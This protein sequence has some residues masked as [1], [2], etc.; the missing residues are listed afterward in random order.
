MS[1]GQEIAPHANFLPAFISQSHSFLVFSDDIKQGIEEQTLLV[2]CL[3]EVTLHVIF[4]KDSFCIH[5]S[6]T[7]TDILNF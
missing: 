3:I 5:Q 1:L 6:E 2:I 4:I 7:A